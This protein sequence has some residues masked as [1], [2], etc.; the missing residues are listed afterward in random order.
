MDRSQNCSICLDNLPSHTCYI[1]SCHHIFHKTCLQSS[2]S[3][4][5]FKC[6]V[7]RQHLS[8]VQ[9]DE[10]NKTPSQLPLNRPS[11]P[12]LNR[13]SQPPYQF[14]DDELA[15]IQLHHTHHQNQNHE[16]QN[17]SP[18]RIRYFQRSHS[19]RLLRERSKKCNHCNRTFISHP[20]LLRHFRSNVHLNRLHSPPSS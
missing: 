20:M 18:S 5:N 9:I 8:I 13:P 17:L 6:P 3:S 11:Q 1:T 16:N 19:R 10:L 14:T 12:P 2:L 7:C 4:G 15:F